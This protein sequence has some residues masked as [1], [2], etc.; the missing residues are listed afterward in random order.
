LHAA[1][2]LKT[3]SKGA[4]RIKGCSCGVAVEGTEDGNIKPSVRRVERTGE[5]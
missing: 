5:L 1:F 2:S 3:D 4:G